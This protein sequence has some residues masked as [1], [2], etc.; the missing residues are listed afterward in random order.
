[1]RM[2][3]SGVFA[4]TRLSFSWRPLAKADTIAAAAVPA[5]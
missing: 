1:M 4:S 5:I 3:I 2:L